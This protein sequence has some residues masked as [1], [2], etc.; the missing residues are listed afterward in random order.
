MLFAEAT[1]SRNQLEII[2][3]VFDDVLECDV[4]FVPDLDFEKN[5]PLRRTGS[6]ETGPR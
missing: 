3:H 2:F 1:C 6:A 5:K 4:I